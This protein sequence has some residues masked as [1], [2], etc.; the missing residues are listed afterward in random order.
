M[1]SRAF[2]HGIC[3][4]F[5]ALAGAASPTSAIAQDNVF[6]HPAS[7][8]APFLYQAERMRWHEH[9]LMNPANGERTWVICPF[10]YHNDYVTESGEWSIEVLIQ[11][12]SGADAEQPKCFYTVHSVLNQKW[13]DYIN[14]TKYEFTKPLPI[15]NLGG[16]R[17][18]ATTTVT[19]LELAEALGSA[20]NALGQMSVYCR[21]NPGWG[22]NS[23]ALLD[24]TPPE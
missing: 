14:G 21:L 17:Y 9:F 7:C 8:V 11:K 5:V 23:V 6:V 16:G 20:F 13:G 24:Q 3:A 1:N 12:M 2:C 4:I 18:G 10:T 22:I 19:A 15:Q